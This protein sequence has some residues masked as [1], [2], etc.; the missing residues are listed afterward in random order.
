MRKFAERSALAFEADRPEEVAVDHQPDA[1]EHAR[2]N[3]AE[4]Q[5][6]DRDVAGR[7]INDGHDAGRNQVRHCRRRC[8]ER[9]GE[10]AVI[11]FTIHFRR[12][13][14]GEHGDVGCRR[15]GNAGKKHA[16][17]CHDLRETAAQMSD[18]RLRQYDHAHGDV[19]RRHQVSDEKEE[20]HRHQRLDVH[21]VED[22]RDHRGFADRREHRDDQD[23]ADQRKCDR[24]PHV[25]EEKE[26][27][28]HQHDE[29]PLGRHSD[30]LF[31][32]GLMSANPLRQPF[33]ICSI[34]KSATSAPQS[35]IA[36]Y[37]VA[38]G[39]IDGMRRLLNPSRKFK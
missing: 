17:Q 30:F 21:A 1:N 15:T 35:G 3:A 32:S 25:A 39:V 26:Q 33:T 2:H 10:S 36:A 24:H 22:L 19:C 16:E 31:S 4:E 18:Q 14:A 7:T 20:R 9:G 29:Q 5:P 23:R 8:D 12:K 13:R 6:A 28:T 11:T 34:V 38:K 27:K 37:K